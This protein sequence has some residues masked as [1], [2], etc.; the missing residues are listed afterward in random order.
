MK[1]ASHNEVQ[2][3]IRTEIANNPLKQCFNNITNITLIVGLVF[4]D[5]LI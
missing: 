4:S 5:I 1:Y 3:T 2:P